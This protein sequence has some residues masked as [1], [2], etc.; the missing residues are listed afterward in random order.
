MPSADRQPLSE[1]ARK[2]GLI[3]LLVTTFFGWGGFFFVVPLIGIHFVDGLGWAAAAVGVALRQRAPTAAEHDDRAA[4]RVD[5]VDAALA[6]LARVEAGAVDEAE[7]VEPCAFGVQSQLMQQL[8]RHER[9]RRDVKP[10]AAAL[11]GFSAAAPPEASPLPPSPALACAA[12]SR[13]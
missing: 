8:L 5:R 11:P 6:R 13:T 3:V 4:R 1:A 7:E 12:S 2:R 10:A 9:S